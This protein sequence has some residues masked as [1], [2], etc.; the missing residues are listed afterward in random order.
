MILNKKIFPC[1]YSFISQGHN[2]FIFKLRG[3]YTQINRIKIIYR[4]IN[5]SKSLD[6]QKEINI[7]LSQILN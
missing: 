5:R 3:K 6:L 2:V 1:L 4:E 7:Q